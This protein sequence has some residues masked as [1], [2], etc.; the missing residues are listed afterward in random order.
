MAIATAVASTGR[1]K[2]LVFKD[3]YHGGTLLFS[4]N[5]ADVNT[6]LPHEFVIAPYNDIH[7]TQSIISALP[8]DS[9]AAILVEPIQGS[10]GCIVGDPKF[11][12]YLDT[13]AHQ[14][15][16]LFIVDEVMT[17][18][19]SYHGLSASLHLTPDLVTLGKWIGGGMSFGAFGGRRDGPMMMFDPRSGVL[20]HSGTFNN[21]I[22]TMA[23]GCVGLDIYNNGEVQRLNELG[24]RLKMGIETVLL[25][26]R[27]PGTQ[28]LTEPLHPGN[29]EV[30]SP[31]QGEPSP[32]I[33]EPEDVFDFEAL[34]LAEAEP[35]MWVSGQ[36]SMLCLHF[37]GESKKTL[38]S[39]LWHHMLENGIYIA[40]RGF[41]ALNLELREEH[42]QL[43]LKALELF[44]MKYKQALGSQ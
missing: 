28:Q 26:S 32:L 13:I 15:G 18:R 43:F 19:L 33:I 7:G 4:S 16:A 24:K 2:I 38:Q 44:V 11:L 6:N 25:K 1:K 37:S 39:L 30:E 10:G 42:I 34:S 9:L 20:S 22:V 21:N 27:I 29:L 36:G 41:I 14:L 8:Q 23:A 5:L 12:Q 40:Q 31:F 35:G 3:G 17:S